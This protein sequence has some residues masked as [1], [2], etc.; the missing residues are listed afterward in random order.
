MKRMDVLVV[1]FELMATTWIVMYVALRHTP[2]LETLIR[3]HLALPLN[4]PSILL[5]H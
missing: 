1:T 5:R 4:T 2:K 3:I